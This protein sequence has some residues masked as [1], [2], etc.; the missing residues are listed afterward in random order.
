MKHSRKGLVV[1]A[2]AVGAVSLL[3]NDARAQV[4]VQQQGRAQDAN[5]RVGSG[6]VNDSVGRGTANYVSSNDIVYNNVTGNRGFRGPLAERDPQ[7][8]TGPIGGRLSDAFIRQSS[9]APLPYQPTADALTPQPFF[10]S[11]RGVAPPLGSIREGY[12][13]AYTGTPLMPQNPDFS[14]EYTSAFSDWR[15]QQLGKSVILG[16]RSSPLDV[17]PGELILQGP[18]EANNQ[19]VLFTGSPLYGVREFQAG[20]QSTDSSA[21]SLYGQPGPA[22]GLRF[23]ESTLRQMRS[24]LLNG[25]FQQ[26]QSP[27]E[28][29]NPNNAGNTG[30]PRGQGNGQGNLNQSLESPD[31]SANNASVNA[32]AAPGTFSNGTNTNQGLQRRSTIPTPGQ[33]MAQYDELQKRMQRYE[34]PEVATIEQSHQFHVEQQRQARASAGHPTAASQPSAYGSTLSP[35]ALEMAARAGAEKPAKP[36]KIT[37]LAAG[38]RFP[39]LRNVLTQAEEQ[40]K[41]NKF[42]TAI[43]TYDAAQ[44]VAPNNWMIRLGRADAELGGGFYA[45]ASDDIHEAYAYAPA[46][47][48]GQYDLNSMMQPQRV[49]HITQELKDLAA[50]NPKDEMP[51]FLLAYIAYNTGDE[52]QAAQYLSQ[53]EERAHGQDAL[54]KVLRQRWYLPEQGATPSGEAP[55]KGDLNK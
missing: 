31:N 41:Q 11:T 27:T 30:Q 50:K 54:L 5:M 25:S 7:A 38:V 21:F 34:S 18:L 28:Q 20:A 44:K 2:A 22:G 4:Q 16:T 46:L 8:F 36:L 45:Q 24:E 39:G 47:T 15:T 37:S 43:E 51:V 14:T 10:G 55:G 9:A 35:R 17:H 3:G 49:Q 6:G 53:A 42:Q 19:A 33:Q 32:S 23:D 1:W 52:A 26:P 29:Q 12:S 48:L 40:M 13:G